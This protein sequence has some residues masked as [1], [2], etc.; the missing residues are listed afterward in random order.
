MLIDRY[1][2]S[3]EFRAHFDWLDPD[4][5]D[6]PIG[7]SGNRASSFFV[8]LVANC[9]G[10]TTVFPEV[11]R[12]DGDQWCDVLKCKDDEGNDVERL[13]VNPKVGTAMFWFHLDPETG[14]GDRRTLHAGAPVLNGTKVG[15][16]IF[17]RQ[18]Q[19]RQS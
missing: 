9:L 2:D 3:Q 15:L 5:P 4:R 14:E 17:T 8:Y 1:T 18:F 12:P 19:W 10:G 16:N 11:P 7:P 6:Y 13:E